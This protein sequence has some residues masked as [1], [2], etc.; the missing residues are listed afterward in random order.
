MLDSNLQNFSVV[1]ELTIAYRLAN[2][3]LMILIILPSSVACLGC[4]DGNAIFFGAIGSVLLAGFLAF[5]VMIY[6]SINL[7]LKLSKVDA[8]KRTIFKYD[9]LNKCLDPQ[10]QFD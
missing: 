6:P 7:I 4:S 9:Y 3:S 10:T 1:D 2:I 8:A 5:C